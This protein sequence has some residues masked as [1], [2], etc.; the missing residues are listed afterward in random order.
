[1]KKIVTL[2]LLLAF[3]LVLGGCSSKE[4]P[5]T[6]NLKVNAENKS[7]IDVYE[8]SLQN[9]IGSMTTILKTFN[10]AVDGLYT[11][12]YSREQF[13]QAIK[14]NIE[15]SNTLVTEV[16]AVDVKPE[17]FEANQNLISLVNRSHQLLLTAIDMANKS[18]LEIDKEYL[19]TEYMDIK[20]KQAEIS[21]QWKILREE[22]E[23]AEKEEAAK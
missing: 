10:N 20:I 7:Y 14:G 23:A 6:G 17:L 1:M 15:K 4:K 11:Q 18:D 2:T 8:K 22:L 5:A 13:A 3:T 19:R 12:D 16:E 21:N 9:Y